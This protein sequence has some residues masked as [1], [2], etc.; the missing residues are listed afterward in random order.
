M[1]CTQTRDRLRGLLDGSLNRDELSPVEDHLEGCVS[2][3]TE[4]DHIVKEAQS[5]LSHPTSAIQAPRPDYLESVKAQGASRGLRGSAADGNSICPGPRSVPG[6][7]GF[8]S[9]P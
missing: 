3:Q 9:H 8:R 7:R 5:A 6:D 1:D 4:L 2:C